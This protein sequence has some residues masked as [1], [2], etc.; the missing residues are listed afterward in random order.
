MPMMCASVCGLGLS[1][2]QE[3]VHCFEHLSDATRV[4]K[5]SQQKLDFFTKQYFREPVARLYCLNKDCIVC[6]SVNLYR[7]KKFWV[8]ACKTYLIYRQAEESDVQ[9]FV[10]KIINPLQFRVL[11]LPTEALVIV[12]LTF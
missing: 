12:P 5:I 7:Y 1:A 9:T 8:V 6:T 11:Y 2:E 4:C 3:A 10:A